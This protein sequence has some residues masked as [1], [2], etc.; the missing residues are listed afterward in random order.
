MKQCQ[1]SLKVLFVIALICSGLAFYSIPT[2]AFTNQVIQKGATGDD[3][4]ELQ[5]RLQYI[6]F[7]NGKIDGVFGWN[8][9]WAVRNYQY[10]F[11]L[12]IDGLVGP[13]MKDMLARSTDYDEQ[14]VQKAL[15]E[16][17][18]FTHYGGT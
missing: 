18:K 10:E 15:N 6:G 17:R 4:L 13:K 8:T 5:S 12:E 16:G 3:V 14:F 7:Y 11:G 1:F 9:Y 2:Y